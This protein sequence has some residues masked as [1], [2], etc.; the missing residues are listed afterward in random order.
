MSQSKYAVQVI[1]TE[2]L[3]R[4]LAETAVRLSKGGRR[5]SASAVLRRCVAA[6]LPVL[7]ARVGLL[8]EV[9]SAIEPVEAESLREALR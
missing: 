4:G 3:S 6:A 9:A 1:L 2:E 5:V 7:M 8:E